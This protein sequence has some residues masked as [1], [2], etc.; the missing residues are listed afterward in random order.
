MHISTTIHYIAGHNYKINTHY[1][2]GAD[3]FVAWK[4]PGRISSLI[5]SVL[6]QSVLTNYVRVYVFT[7]IG[8]G[9]GRS[10]CS[11]TMNLK[12]FYSWEV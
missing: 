12:R 10:T 7:Y 4:V 11:G 2:T 1:N 9:A 5:L 8:T 6:R 3:E